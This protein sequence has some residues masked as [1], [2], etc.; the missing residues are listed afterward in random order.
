MIIFASC[1]KISIE[2]TLSHKRD[3]LTL[4]AIKRG[5]NM[6]ISE[7]IL[8]IGEKIE[9]VSGAKLN[10]SQQATVPEEKW[11]PETQEKMLLKSVHLRTEK[12]T[13]NLEVVKLKK[14][15]PCWLK[16]NSEI[17]CRVHGCLKTTSR[18]STKRRTKQDL[19]LCEAH[20]ENLTNFILQWCARENVYVTSFQNSN[21]CEGYTSLIGALE[22]AFMHLKSKRLTTTTDALLAEVFLNTRNF[23]IITNALLN[24]D[25]DNT[26]TAVGPYLTILLRLLGDPLR[27]GNLL[28]LLE[29]VMN[30][31][32]HFF[33]IIY[34]WVHVPLENPGAKIGFGLGISFGFL[35]A[36]VLGFPFWSECVCCLLFAFAG[37][38]IGSGVYDWNREPRSLEKVRQQNFKN[39]LQILELAR[40]YFKRASTPTFSAPADASGNLNIEQNE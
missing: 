6:G 5:E 10:F 39:Q 3:L 33:G 37:S 23:L 8:D 31:V 30:L 1:G 12:Q 24:P 36:Q 22:K 29:G 15:D 27:L 32:L 18:L 14:F 19:F 35:L 17:S 7:F 4:K 2:I 9:E 38:L 20:R 21:D 28:K 25:E 16:A 26:P 34:Q 11:I 40:R 13:Q